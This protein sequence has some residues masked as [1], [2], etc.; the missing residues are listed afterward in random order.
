MLWLILLVVDGL[1][2]VVAPALD[3]G[4]CDLLSFSPGRVAA[5]EH[6]VL[7]QNALLLGCEFWGIW[8]GHCWS[9]LLSLCE[10][11][12]LEVPFLLFKFVGVVYSLKIFLHAFVS[13]GVW[14]K[15]GSLDRLGEI[16]LEG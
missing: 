11:F 7:F 16:G 6:L 5:R 3:T 4:R 1:G 9:P 14:G 13:L 2:G 8:G 15:L 12:V 10:D